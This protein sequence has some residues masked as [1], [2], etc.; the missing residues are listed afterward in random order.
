MLNRPFINDET[1]SSEEEGEDIKIAAHGLV[2]GFT[3]SIFH[4]PPTSALKAFD[5]IGR[6]LMAHFSKPHLLAQVTS[7]RH[8]VSIFKK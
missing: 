8:I 1:I 5:L 3:T 7:V 2:N 4:S 6:H